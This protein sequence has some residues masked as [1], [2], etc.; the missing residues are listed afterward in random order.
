MLADIVDEAGTLV[1]KGRGAD[2]LETLAFVFR[3]GE[4]LIAIVDVGE[5]MLVVMELQGLG[6]HE[7]LQGVV[8]IGQ[9]WKLEGHGRVL[10]S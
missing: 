7:G 2:V 1:G 8:G 3:P 4:Q 10:R 5:M 6:R 9:V